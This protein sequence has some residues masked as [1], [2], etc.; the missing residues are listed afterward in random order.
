M[1]LPLLQVGDEAIVK[2][3]C[4]KNDRFFYGHLLSSN[5]GETGGAEL[6]SLQDYI[7]QPKTVALHR[8]YSKGIYPA[9]TELVLVKFK[10]GK[11]YRGKIL[12]QYEDSSDSIMVFLVD[13]GTAEFFSLSN[14]YK[15]EPA[16]AYLP[17]QAIQFIIGGIQAINSECK[18][19]ATVELKRLIEFQNV[20]I[21]V[22]GNTSDLIVKVLKDGMDISKELFKKG[23]VKQTEVVAADINQ[24]FYPG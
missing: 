9:I 14:I 21:Q 6:F 2:V 4:V 16:F 18:L 8:P 11:F 22:L 7:N 3:T 1:D 17:F 20:N 15:W 13:Y 12:R 19:K 23:L 10:D 5:I 24:K